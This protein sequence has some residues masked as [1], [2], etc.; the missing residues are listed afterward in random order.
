MITEKKYSTKVKEFSAIKHV[1]LILINFLTQQIWESKV[2]F[3]KGKMYRFWRI[4]QIKR[5]MEFCHPRWKQE[6]IFLEH[7]MKNVHAPSSG[8]HWVCISTF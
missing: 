2:S 3:N 1:S 5:D 7:E 6:R 4:N 8:F